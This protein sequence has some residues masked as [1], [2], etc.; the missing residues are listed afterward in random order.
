VLTVLVVGDGAESID[1]PVER[2]VL[3]HRVGW[4]TTLLKV[5]TNLGSSALLW[6]VAAI[7]AA[8]VWWRRRHWAS[9]LMPVAALAGV[10]LAKA[11][12]KSAVDRPRPPSTAWLTSATGLAYPSGHAMQALAVFVALALVLSEGRRRAVR[13]A[14]WVG[15]SLIVL[16]VG[17]SQLYLGVHW[18]TDVIGGY[19]LAGAWVAVLEAGRRSVRLPAAPARNEQ[20]PPGPGP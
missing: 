5:L 14:A 18:L 16:T 2:W 1:R 11:V 13:T 7:G 8:I 20:C 3:A 19:A 10:V 17:W 4:F 6:A 12:V 9:A 15:A